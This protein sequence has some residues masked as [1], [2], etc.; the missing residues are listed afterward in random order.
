MITRAT[1]RKGRMQALQTL[2]TLCLLAGLAFLVPYEGFPV[3]GKPPA[4]YSPGLSKLPL[5]FEPNA[6][7]SNQAVRFL[8]R[9][10]GGTL[11]FTPSGVSLTLNQTGARAVAAKAP[12]VGSPLLSHETISPS[13]VVRILFSGANPN[14]IV[15][16]GVLLPGKVNYMLGNDPAQW[17]TDLPT[18]AGITYRDLYPGINLTYEGTDGLLKGT[19]N[20]S[21]GA[22]P[23]HIRWRYDGTQKVAIDKAGNLQVTSASTTLTEQAPIAWQDIMGYRVPVD[24]R[25]TLASDGTVSF[26]LGSYN[27]AY[28]LTIDPT[29][30][31]S[32]YLGG[33]LL[34][35]AIR[36][37][38]DA[39][40]NTYVTGYTDSINFPTATPYQPAN[41][42]GGDAFIAKLDPTGTQ[43]L[44]AT[45][46]GGSAYDIGT[47]L[48]VDIDGSI[49]LGGITSSTNFPLA[50]ALQPAYGGGVYDGF[51]TKLN[52]SGSA[53]VYS[54]F[55]GGNG[56]DQV[57]NMDINGFDVYAV[58]E[59]TSSNF[60]LA[61]PYQPTLNGGGDAFVSKI[62]SSGSMLSYSTYLGGSGA[63]GGYGIAVDSNGSAYV[64]G[65][66]RSFNFPTTNAIQPSF[67]GG[68]GD[69][70]VTKLATSGV[71]L[72][73][74]TYL[75]GNGDDVGLDMVVDTIGSAYTTGVTASTN[76]PTH[77]PL[78]PS[79]GGSYDMYVSKLIATG[80]A[81]AYSTYLGGSATEYDTARGCA[82]GIDGNGNVYVAGGTFSTNYPIVDPIQPANAGGTDMVVTKINSAG[83]A[84]VYSTYLGGSNNDYAYDV[85]VDAVGNTYIAGDTA[86]TNFPTLNPYQPANAGGRDAFV[87]L[88][89]GPPTNTP[90]STATPTATATST[91]TPTAT[92]TN[93][94]TATPTN[95]PTNTPT[96]TSTP[97]DTATPTNTP[98]N[99][100]T[101]TDTATPTSTACTISFTDVPID[102]PFYSFIRCLACRN[103]IS[104]YSDGTFRPGNDITRSQIAKMV[105]NAA[106]FSEDP[107][108]QIYEDVDS[109]NIF[110]DWINRLSMRGHMG[111][112]PCG[113]VPEEPCNP[114][115]NR[116]YFRPFA[117][118][119]RGQLAKIVANAAG[120]GGTPTGLFYTDVPEDNPFYL[121][122]MRLTAIGVMSGYPCGTIP[123]E[124]CDEANR[125]YFRPF[126]NVTRGQASKIVAN[127]FFSGCETP[128]RPKVR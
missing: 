5:S 49:Y 22:D 45:Y 93:T 21:P 54:T 64:T 86:S 28:A 60:P 119:T 84:L 51:I 128:A 26:A 74:S 77:N 125:P 53:V 124:P 116:P 94:P 126:T 56:S 68:A 91:N 57:F 27:R 111:G 113:L 55:L 62:N 76:F 100:S 32:T 105:S 80:A 73:Y 101:A 104:G 3:V 112:Y 71:S 61:N 4:L 36:V 103:I 30:I 118:A 1:T 18:Y 92:P 42:G 12:Q 8:A 34:D 44:Y 123:E 102:H 14:P 81:F 2:G 109:N 31:Y 70:Y 120:I 40:G 52:A 37:T 20:V 99:T 69:A 117:N 65:V 58:G 24:A 107:G 85:A 75:G 43:L 39:L 6:G 63:E 33:S 25:Y 41:A 67:G 66:T 89:A 87:A 17:H 23:G 72:L 48:R 115:N 38:L 79:P 110:Y 83:S 88:I 108:P 11:F 47:G 114:P 127:T 95:T 82:L 16:N 106:G 122:I 90:T 35:Y 97:T 19:Y 59:T 29:L 121:W 78:Q 10:S 15:D 50:N 9:A 13:T 46:F 96:A 7:Q 98:T